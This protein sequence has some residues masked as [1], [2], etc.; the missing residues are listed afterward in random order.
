MEVRLPATG[1][2]PVVKVSVSNSGLTSKM[3]SYSALLITP[4]EVSLAEAGVRRLCKQD[5]GQAKSREKDHPLMRLFRFSATSV[6]HEGGCT[7]IPLK[8]L[9][10]DQNMVGPGEIIACACSVDLSRFRASSTCA[11]RYL[12]F[13]SYFGLY[14]RWR[15][16]ADA[17]RVPVASTYEK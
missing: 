10:E 14:V 16:T 3:I 11:V 7:L 6:Q 2:D 15:F 8:E 12:I 5:A 1:G 13:I 9:Y 17:V 4:E